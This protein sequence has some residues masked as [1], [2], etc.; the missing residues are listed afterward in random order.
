MRDLTSTQGEKTEAKVLAG[1]EAPPAHVQTAFVLVEER[2]PAPQIT[3]TL[4][5]GYPISLRIK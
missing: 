3:N 5:S 1:G 4:I 2:S